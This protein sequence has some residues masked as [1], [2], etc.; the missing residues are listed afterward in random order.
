MSAVNWLELI[1]MNNA[2][3]FDL[4][5]EEIIERYRQRIEQGDR[6]KLPKDELGQL[7]LHFVDR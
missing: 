1:C 2:T 7:A 5:R 4:T 6:T 3:R